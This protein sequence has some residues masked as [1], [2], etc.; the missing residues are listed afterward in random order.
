[1]NPKI[2]A[3]SALCVLALLGAAPLENKATDGGCSLGAYRSPAGDLVAITRPLDG[4]TDF[5]YTL[6]NG[7]RGNTDSPES[8]IRCQGGTFVG[9]NAE[10]F[11][12]VAFRAT[13]TTFASEG[14]TLYGLLLEPESVVN[15]PL[16]IFVH[17]SERAS[18]IGI[19]YEAML[20]GQGVATFFYDKRGTGKSTGT[21]TQDFL[22]LAKDAANAAKAARKLAAG[23]YSRFGFFGGSQGGW[24][25][26]LA[27]LDSHAD[28]LEVAFGVVGTALEQD[29]WQVDYQLAQAGFG[30]GILPDVHH[31]TDVTASVVGSDFLNVT[32]L[33]A[34]SQQYSGQPWFAQI[35]GQYS[36]DLLKGKIASVKSDSETLRI[37]WH[38]TGLE[39]LRALQIPQLW[40]FAKDD[41]VAP[42]ANSIQ[43][44]EALPD[45]GTPRSIVVF[46]NT[47]HGIITF[48]TG[49]DGKR[50]SDGNLADGYLRLLA[51]FAK[52]T[53]SGSYGNGDWVKTAAALSR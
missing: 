48:H 52:G 8:P 7:R 17:G 49:T 46:P 31:V 12:R 28:F 2:S 27:A 11:T 10:A 32:D 43:R 20:T 18:D 35:D 16:V 1:V 38:Y 47:D 13:P 23:R 15:P 45:N 36:G 39:T 6:L 50:Q 4:R 42:S 3:I 14:V 33:T 5:R 44:L 22:L 41:S 51:D 9:S 24:V 21:Y 40:V 37:P 29:Q 26:P 30:P 25:A 19:Y 53:I 34:V